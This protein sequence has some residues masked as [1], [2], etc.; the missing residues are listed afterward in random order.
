MAD[1][2]PSDRFRD[3]FCTDGTFM[4]TGSRERGASVL[5]AV[6]GVL[7]PAGRFT[8]TLADAPEHGGTGDWHWRTTAEYDGYS[9][10]LQEA[11]QPGP[12]PRTQLVLKRIDK[13]DPFGHRVDSSVRLHRLYWWTREEIEADC[14]AAGF[15]DVCHD[16]QGDG[17]WITTATAA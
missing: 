16:E 15:A 4:L 7:E 3:V 6:V 5:R 13:F 11:R 2:D 9:Y 12:K 10:T 8:L 17:L 14:S 1:L